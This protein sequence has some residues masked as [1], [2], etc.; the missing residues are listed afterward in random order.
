MN[1]LR[2]EIA[3]WN[4][5]R[6]GRESP[7]MVL[8]RLGPCTLIAGLL[9]SALAGPQPSAP[10]VL[11]DSAAALAALCGG[12][13]PVM[14][15]YII[16]TAI[17]D[18]EAWRFCGPLVACDTSE[19][20][21]RGKFVL[22]PM[23]TH[24][25]NVLTAM[26]CLILTHASRYGVRV[27]LASAALGG[28]F[29][30]MGLASFCWWS[31][32]RHLCGLVDNWLMEVHLLAMA[33]CVLSVSEPGYEGRLV[34]GWG[35]YSALRLAMSSGHADLLVPAV[36]TWGGALLATVRTGGSGDVWRFMLGAGGVHCGLALKMYDTT[37][38]GTWGTAAFHYATAL[39]WTSFWAW[40]QTLPAE[41][42]R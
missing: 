18:S 23:A 1:A 14:F 17:L 4:S 7:L 3:L 40:T 35:G 31:S 15:F 30:A 16:D 36:A 24:S 22:Y 38:R 26:G 21:R 12:L 6:H 19:R 32:Q 37:G 8:S 41:Q 11:L 27:P 20:Q 34:L 2:A 13:L 5:A 25:S 33:A 29:V 39:G 10:F 9:L 28:S 42:G